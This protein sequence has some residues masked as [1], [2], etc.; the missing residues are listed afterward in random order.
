MH[1]KPYIA[2]GTGAVGGAWSLCISD[3][4]NTV[5]CTAGSCDETSGGVTGSYYATQSE[6]EAFAELQRSAANSA[7][8]QG[9]G[10]MG[11]QPP[12]A[13][14]TPAT[15]LTII[16][17]E[18]WNPVAGARLGKFFRYLRNNYGYD[19]QIP[20]LKSDGSVSSWDNGYGKDKIIEQANS[21]HAAGKNVVLMCYSNGCGS[22]RDAIKQ[23][24]LQDMEISLVVFFDASF[25]FGSNWLV[26]P[27][28]KRLINIYSRGA[29][30][31]REIP[32]E[33][34]PDISLTNYQVPSQI[35]H[36][37]MPYND[38]A[39]MQQ[40]MESDMYPRVLAEL[41]ALR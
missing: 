9:S 1:T 2:P 12:S 24:N 25:L 41:N 34:A 6:C 36:L 10:D 32:Q 35:G 26:S 23:L 4:D 7:A 30:S 29:F 13:G 5:W 19:V 8:N 16:G 28:V 21:A 39:N 14:V 33:M 15:G 18:G 20:D 27:N 22:T 11:P 3:L 38:N 31:G 40:T 17:T 37:D